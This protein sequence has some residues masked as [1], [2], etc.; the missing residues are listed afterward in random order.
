MK[1]KNTGKKSRLVYNNNK[2]KAF[3]DSTSYPGFKVKL[4]SLRES[5][6]YGKYLSDK[7]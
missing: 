5:L 4:F 1:E 2:N 6:L 3:F 7:D